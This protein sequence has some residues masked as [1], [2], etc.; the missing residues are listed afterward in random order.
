MKPSQEIEALC[1]K[2]HPIIGAEADKLWRMYL[3]EDELGR[4]D[5]AIDIEIL[6]E[7]LLG[8]EDMEDKEIL[9]SPPTEQEAQGDFILGNVIYNQKKLHPLFLKKEDYLK[10]VGIF[11]M[12]GEGK[13]NLAHLLA[14]QLLKAKIPF[15]VIDWKRSW[16]N[17][18]SLRDQIPELKDVQVFT[19][20]RDILPFP[21]NPFRAPPGAN[22]EQW[23]GVISEAL[24]RSHL[25]GPGVAHH[26]NM[27]YSKLTST[28]SE[29]FF[30]TFQDGLKEI[31][32]IQT[33]M[34][35]LMWKQTAMRIFHSFTVGEAFK[36][37][38]ARNPIRLE[39]LLSKPVILELDLELPKPLRVF[40]SEMILRWIHLFRLNQGETGDVRHVLFLEEAHNFFQE[41]S[42]LTH[43]ASSIENVYREIRAFGQGIVSI[44]QHPSQLPVYLLGNCHT[45]IYLGLQHAEDIKAAWQSLFLN[46]DE[47][48]YP[49]RL[50]VGECIVKIKNRIEPCLIKTPLV[51]I[52]KGMINDSWL[53]ENTPAYLSLNS[54]GK[55]SRSPPVFPAP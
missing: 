25:S 46:I 20:G 31:E 2:L 41:P 40:F 38:N 48:S 51:P 42:F 37:F 47:R 6:A 45:Q 13:T 12:T 9:L 16:R 44:T 34:R 3:S 10:Q 43:V 27:I 15:L 8:K 54:D 1:K 49:N 55:N 23:V 5:L 26:F 52:K 21:W 53:K 33:T 50:K 29:D 4:R 7:K 19:V 17:L 22:Q 30:P 39:A 32:K 24:E 18:L 35:E 28:I 36:V 14:S 11:A